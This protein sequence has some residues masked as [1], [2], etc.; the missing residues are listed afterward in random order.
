MHA[1]SSKVQELVQDYDQTF[2]FLPQYL[3]EA[4]YPYLKDPV[5]KDSEVWLVPGTNQKIMFNERLSGK[6]LFMI[7]KPGQTILFYDGI[8]EQ[9]LYRY[10]GKTLVCFV[11]GHS[12]FASE[13][14]FRSFL[15]E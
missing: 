11:D 10:N 13:E 9:P 6:K 7:S 15:W 14:V 2:A 3:E 8:N 4:L 5:L 12:E 1:L